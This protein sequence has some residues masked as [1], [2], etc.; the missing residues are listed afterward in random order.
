MQHSYVSITA[1]DTLF[2]SSCEGCLNSCCDGSRFH[3]APLIL[4][5][6]IEVFR[7]FPIVFGR[8][9]QEWR[10]MILFSGDGE[11]CRYFKEGRCGGYEH[12]PPACRIYPLTPYYEDILID[13]SCH[14]VCSEKGAFLASPGTIN[15]D[16]YHQ[17][18]ENFEMKRQATQRYMAELAE[19]FELVGEK[20]GV[21]YYRYTGPIRDQYIQMHEDS[22][23]LLF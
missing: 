11:A 9:A 16:F 23:R 21:E 20:G 15:T 1:I 13:T 8:I 18:L 17:R 14:T 5:D 2:F 7:Y 3:F 4:D 12:R 6:F 19:Q 10:P 22:L